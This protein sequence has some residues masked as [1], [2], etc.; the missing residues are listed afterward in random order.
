MRIGREDEKDRR[1][2]DAFPEARGFSHVSET[3]D[4]ALEKKKHLL[5]LPPLILGCV[6]FVS[7]VIVVH[8]FQMSMCVCR[9]VVFFGK[10]ETDVWQIVQIRDCSIKIAEFYVPAGHSNWFC[11]RFERRLLVW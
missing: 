1:F 10:L 11:L 7:F 9:N 8:W 3:G 6:D 2:Q 4:C 5:L